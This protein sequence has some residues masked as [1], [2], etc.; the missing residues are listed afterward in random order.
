MVNRGESSRRYGC[1]LMSCIGIGVVLIVCGSFFFIR[2]RTR[3]LVQAEL[4]RIRDAGLPATP[5]EA[6]KF[7]AVPDGTEEI[8][9]FWLDAIGTDVD[10]PFS[11]A[12]RNQ[13]A[14]D[15]QDLPYVGN[16]TD[17]PL[18]GQPWA[19]LQAAREF[20]GGYDDAM[21]LVH[22]AARQEGM[23]RFPVKLSDGFAALL[24][25][26]QNVRTPARMLR[27][28]ALVRAHDGDAHGAAE[29]IHAMFMAAR[30]LDREPLLI[31]TL[32]H[33]ALVSSA[34]QSTRELVPCVAFSDDD[35]RSLQID[36]RRARPANI[37][38]R[39]LATER[40]IGSG[41][42]ENPRQASAKSGMTPQVSA[43]M[44]LSGPSDQLMYLELMERFI[45][46]AKLEPY[47]GIEA[48]KLAEQELL[49]IASG[50]LSRIR[51]PI[52]LT[53]VPAI[54]ASFKS[55]SRAIAECRLV[56]ILVGVERY[57]R[58]HNAVPNSLRELV[59]DF[60]PELWTD[61]FSGRDFVYRIDADQIVIYSIGSDGVD[62]G[63]IVE[64]DST[65]EVVV[66]LRRKAD[67]IP[68]DNPSDGDCGTQSLPKANF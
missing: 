12:N 23:V 64:Q 16:V 53:I 7:Y 45:A 6:D 54:L 11:R 2:S 4:Q 25:Y 19:D 28:Q 60:L 30:T 56:D 9:A 67:S 10:P 20:L 40:A 66:T 26:T 34:L 65:K 51:H 5:A 52:S 62:R 41:F 35:L 3:G 47:A 50:K 31:S 49:R 36:I 22:L 58:Q 15:T 17:P 44:L 29:S 18:P 21:K 42:F 59:P 33:A 55:H 37:L 13:F 38:Y 63:G 43:G 32:V 27:L 1:L 24:P 39:G 61:P 57:R 14:V 8:T 68:I 48:C 46:A